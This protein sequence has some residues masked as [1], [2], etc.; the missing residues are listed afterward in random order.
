MSINNLF[1]YVN[2]LTNEW[3]NGILANIIIDEVE[4]EDK[5]HKWIILD[6]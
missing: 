4:K 6:G 2:P 5:I 3:T 1:G